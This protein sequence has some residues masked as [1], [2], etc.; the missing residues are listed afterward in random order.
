[1]SNNV[2]PTETPNV[3][4]ANPIV[5]KVDRRFRPPHPRCDGRVSCGERAGD[6]PASTPR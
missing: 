3:V 1:M 2:G 6:I 5:R 4:I